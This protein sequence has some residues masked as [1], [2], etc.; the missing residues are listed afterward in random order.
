MTKYIV[1]RTITHEYN[2]LVDAK[3]PEEAADAEYYGKS[4][5]TSSENSETRTEVRLYVDPAE[6]ASKVVQGTATQQ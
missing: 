3:T 4:H 6:V 2:W 5:S 1:T